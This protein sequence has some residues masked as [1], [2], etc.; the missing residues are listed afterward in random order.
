MLNLLKHWKP[1]NR[2][3][4][5]ASSPSAALPKQH[6]WTW[7]S[8]GAPC[9]CA[10]PRPSLGRL[11]P[12]ASPAAPGAAQ[13]HSA[14]PQ[15]RGA[16]ESIRVCGRAPIILPSARQA[17]MQAESVAA[18]PRGEPGRNRARRAA[19]G[20]S[21]EIGPAHQRA[22]P[23]P[24]SRRAMLTPDVLECAV[25]DVLGCAVARPS[26]PTYAACYARLR[27]ATLRA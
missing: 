10:Q 21:S 16:G 15:L 4:A 20:T 1:Q 25:A 27:A 19:A 7:L 24:E 26:L 12:H 8:L 18:G 5:A 13:L 11:R 3:S 22:G 6:L 23:A 14:R 17:Q 2:F 9:Q